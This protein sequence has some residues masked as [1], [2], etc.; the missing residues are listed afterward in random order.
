M[1]NDN[2]NDDTIPDGVPGEDEFDPQGANPHAVPPNHEG[3]MSVQIGL[4]QVNGLVILRVGEG[5]EM[6]QTGL[7]I[8]GAL[9]LAHNIFGKCLS[10]LMGPPPESMQDDPND[11]S[12]GGSGIILPGQGGF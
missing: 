9:Q 10:A 12:G 3:A 4:D 8:A 11:P 6:V 2:E 1:T 5:D 7:P